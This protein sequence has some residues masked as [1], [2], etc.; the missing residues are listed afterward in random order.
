MLFVVG[1]RMK[2]MFHLYIVSLILAWM[3]HWIDSKIIHVCHHYTIKLTAILR[4]SC[5]HK[6]HENRIPDVSVSEPVLFTVN[7]FFCRLEGDA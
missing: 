3:S 6:R 5:M 2:A 7:V 4:F 1:Q